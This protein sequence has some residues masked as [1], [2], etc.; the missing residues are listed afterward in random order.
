MSYKNLN[1]KELIK[2]I[3]ENNIEY[4]T[5]EER[6]TEHLQDLN[7]EN[8]KNMNDEDFY[9]TIINKKEFHDTKYDVDKM[10][11][12][13]KD[14][15]K[16][17]CPSE[18]K[19]FKLLNHQIFVKNYINSMTPYK[20]LLLFHGLGCHGIDTPIM[21][22]DKS[23][24]MVQDIQVGDQLMGD[25][26]T[27]RNVL[28]LKRGVD[29]MYKIKPT[30]EE[31]FI[32]NQN[33]ILSLIDENQKITDI[34][35]TDYI[36]MND[37]EKSILTL[38]K[39]SWSEKEILTFNFEVEVLKV[40]DFYGFTLDN[41]HR[42]VDGNFFVQHNSG[43]SCSAIS[44]AETYKRSLSD[45]V[46]NKTLVLVSGSTIEENFRKEIHDIERGFNQCTFSDYMNY[47]PTELNNIKQKKVDDLI[48]TYYEI[49]HYQKFTNIINN[50]RN[51][52]E[53]NDY[54]KWIENNYSNRVL[55]IDEVHNLKD[56]VDTKGNLKRYDIVRDIVSYSKNLRLILLSGTPMSHSAKEII[57]IINL[58]LYNE[59]FEPLDLDDFFDANDKLI[60]EKY[61][62]LKIICRGFIS[63]VRQENPLT[64]PN[65]TYHGV[66]ID[67][68]IS[69]KFKDIK[70]EIDNREDYTIVPC[71]MIS[72]QKKFYIDY[73]KKDKINSTEIIQLGL[74][75]YDTTKKASVYKL[76][77]NEFHIDRIKTHSTKYFELFQNIMKSP[78]GP[79]FVYSN[80]RERG[81]LMIASVLLRNGISL[82]KKARSND[83]LLFTKKEFVQPRVQPKNGLCYYCYNKK[84]NCTYDNH[85]YSQMTFEYIIGETMEEVQSKIIQVYRSSENKNGKEIKI[86]L[87]SSVL[88]EGVSFKSVREIHIMEPWHNFSRI[89]QVIGRGLRHCSHKDLD[90]KDRHVDIY[91]YASVLSETYETNKNDEY[92]TI[93][94]NIYD[95]KNN[96][97]PVDIIKLQKNGEPLL[98]Y[99]MAVY[100]RALILNK[101]IKKIEKV[102]KSV[103]VDCFLNKQLNI[104]TLE[105][106]EEKYECSFIDYQ[107]IQE[108]ELDL[109]T[110]KTIF[111]LPYINYAI[112]TIKEMF[113][114]KIF[115]TLNNIIDHEEFKTQTIYQDN[116]YDIIK[117]ALKTMEPL[118][119]EF[120]LFNHIFK[121]GVNN[122]YGYIF[123]R[124]IDNENIYIFQDL[125]DDEK[126]RSKYE[127]YPLYYRDKKNGIN[128]L[129]NLSS[130]INFINY[131]EDVDL[132]ETIHTK[133]TESNISKAKLGKLSSQEI[134]KL[135]PI[136]NHKND[137]IYIGIEINQ[138]IFKGMLW[139]RNY[140]YSEEKLTQKQYNYGK[141][142]LSYDRKE[143][144]N[145][146]TI[147]WE[148]VL[149]LKDN[150]FINKYKKII[151]DINKD[152]IRKKNIKCD[153]IKQLLLYLQKN[154]PEKKK[155][156]RVL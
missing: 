130:F 33:H 118:D 37:N 44:I 9:P 31:S 72:S 101:E 83:T 80:Y 117:K 134:K 75:G 7:Y 41:N 144:T 46:Y 91:Q 77:F 73:V 87:G 113:K 57:N 98:S 104:D 18:D 48:D 63:Y 105:N 2:I 124:I 3:N 10:L 145:I 148:K 135:D 58:M 112:L 70:I 116:N 153:V 147:L 78:K 22:F 21:M 129:N 155:W 34:K 67:E 127:N 66:L 39:P 24:K 12:G 136:K 71:K 74:F 138:E 110:Y 140:S 88:K 52:L 142:C 97:V 111:K 69:K 125:D 119:D 16:E 65:K 120:I 40:D 114:G 132:Y 150:T 61:E 123:S 156:F 126:R 86:L 99:D 68:Y 8:Y 43:K 53:D 60:E 103:A 62:E 59:G 17:L 30:N 151:T 121:G 107:K 36:D 89:K 90:E 28:E 149:L 55:I 82:S 154:D 115:L 109:S 15:Q 6:I 92:K 38:Y 128:N 139:L 131:K 20:S 27:P 11:K 137:A 76:P 85:E 81:I 141:N 95:T 32:V 35:L 84:D 93:L 49:E 96:E 100:K 13:A 29:L 133:D 47:R 94:Q 23:I 4:K 106:E 146:I 143:L 50:M 54:E 152:I 19:R 51:T 122:N 108:E 25:D 102:L 14:S 45:N 5:E 56:K 64:F 79:I 26:E 1:L 42:Y